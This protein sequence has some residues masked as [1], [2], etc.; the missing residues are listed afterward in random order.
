MFCSNCGSALE[1]GAKFCN[2]CGTPVVPLE[3]QGAGPQPSAPQDSVPQWTMSQPEESASEA[4][5]PVGAQ[6]GVSQP[7]QD[8]NARAEAYIA[9]TAYGQQPDQAY[10]L[11]GQPVYQQPGVDQDFQGQ[12]K[13]RKKLKKRLI[14]GGSIAAACIAVGVT[15][16]VA[17]AQIRNFFNSMKSPEDYYRIVETD[18]TDSQGKLLMNAYNVGA[19]SVHADSSYEMSARLKISPMLQTMLGSFTKTAGGEGSSFDFSKFSD[20]EFHTRMGA[21]DSTELALIGEVSVNGEKLFDLTTY[22]NMGTGEN[23]ISLPSLGDAFLKVGSANMF[24][25]SQKFETIKMLVQAIPDDETLERIVKRYRDIVLDGITDVQKSSGTLTVGTVSQDCTV[26]DI[27]L[28]GDE[29][30]NIFKNCLTQMESDEDLKAIFERLSELYGY[31]EMTYDKL[32]KML[33]GDYDRIG[34]SNVFK[35]LKMTL[36]VDSEGSVIGRRINIENNT[37][38]YEIMFGMPVS[39]GMFEFVLSAAENGDKTEFITGSGTCKGKKLTGD[40]K[41]GVDP[42]AQTVVQVEELDLSALSKGKLSGSLIYN[43]PGTSFGGVKMRLDI[44]TD[45]TDI[46]GKLSLIYVG[47]PLASLEFDGG[48][49]GFPTECVPTANDKVYD[50]SVPQESQEFLNSLNIDGWIQR[51]KDQ[52]GI[53]LSFIKKY[54]M[55]RE[56]NGGFDGRIIE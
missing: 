54:L 42:M 3:T 18:C 48:V 10:V 40:F 7:E 43:L 5:Q 13:S 19:K 36:Y 4:A 8:W 2:M 22:S 16:I 38:K 12:K 14:I 24:S 32:I 20:I 21:K 52:I 51:V 9:Q 45:M 49:C 31:R 11:N 47:E 35:S 1:D 53:D 15:F 44:D 28:S 23:F 6:P 34:I 41:I 30:N 26:L 25:G 46:S 37:D 27:S 33:L 17:G 50:S 55:L 56:T 39:H 29:L